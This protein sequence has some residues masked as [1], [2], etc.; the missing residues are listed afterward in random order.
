MIRYFG[1][2]KYRLLKGAPLTALL[3]RNTVADSP[4]QPTETRDGQRAAVILCPVDGE[5]QYHEEP[6]TWVTQSIHQAFFESDVYTATIDTAQLAP[7][8][9][10]VQAELMPSKERVAIPE[11]VWILDREQYQS[12]LGEELGFQE[13]WA[14]AAAPADVRDLITNVLVGVL[15]DLVT[16]LGTPVPPPDCVYTPDPPVAGH[17]PLFVLASTVR[18][19]CYEARQFQ[20]WGAALS[21]RFESTATNFRLSMTFLLDKKASPAMTILPANLAGALNDKEMNEVELLKAL[22]GQWLREVLVDA[23]P[24][25]FFGGITVVMNSQY[26]FVA[27]T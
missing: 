7:G 21:W 23:I 24:D 13:Q 5:K 12:L 10:E 8:A 19:L 9:Y 18:A 27:T 4:D 16:P 2:G 3:I 17:L 6:L 25:N 26:S 1:I 22:R 15:G 11:Y 14:D 20:L